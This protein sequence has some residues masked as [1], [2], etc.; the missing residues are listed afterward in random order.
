MDSFIVNKL[1]KYL[2][3]EQ[4]SSYLKHAELFRVWFKDRTPESYESFKA[5]E[6]NFLMLTN[7][8]YPCELIPHS[9]WG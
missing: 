3:E 9:I 8:K 1:R 5:E 4:L 7:G 6:Q 2:T